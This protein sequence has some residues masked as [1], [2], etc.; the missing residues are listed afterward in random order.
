MRRTIRGGALLS[1]P[2]TRNLT[3]ITDVLSPARVGVVLHGEKPCLGDGD[4][5]LIGQRLAMRGELPILCP[6]S[7]VARLDGD[8]LWVENDRQDS[9]LDDPIPGIGKPLDELTPADLIGAIRQAGIPDRQ[10]RPLWRR[11]ERAAESGI[12]LAAVAAFDTQP[13]DGFSASLA[14]LCADRLISA[15]KLILVVLSAGQGRIVLSFSDREGIRAIRKAVGDFSARIRIQRVLPVYPAQSERPL[16]SLLTG[17]ELSSRKS[18]EN[19]GVLILYPAELLAVADLFFEGRLYTHTYVSVDGVGVDGPLLLRV[20]VGTGI[21]ELPEIGNRL[22]HTRIVENGL[23]SGHE[24]RPDGFVGPTT[25]ALSVIRPKKRRSPER[26]IG[27][28]ACFAACPMYLSPRMILS[29]DRRDDSP[30]AGFLA[31]NPVTGSGNLKDRAACCIGCGCCS[32][33]CPANLPLAEEMAALKAEI[34]PDVPP[35]APTVASAEIPAE[36]DANSPVSPE[37]SVPTDIPEPPN[38]PEPSNPPEA[39]IPEPHGHFHGQLDI[40]LFSDGPAPDSRP[41]PESPPSDEPNL[42][43]SDRSEVN[44][45]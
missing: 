45:P 7:G 18:P 36:S 28:D 2:K 34:A 38:V 21:G 9:E 14:A 17:K 24:V 13:G 26:C 25:R 30:L 42:P 20:P 39:P 3:E 5:V 15:L 16:F 4:P 6:I 43:Q 10:G 27:C 40:P 29:A 19:A 44:E 35:R 32:Y 41:E 33:V 23:M 37:D 31:E 8:V 11:L 12:Y 22:R 1:L